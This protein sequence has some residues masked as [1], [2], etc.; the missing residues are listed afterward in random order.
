MAYL[1]NYNSDDQEEDNN[2]K[3]QEA[4]D[5]GSSGPAPIGSGGSQPAPYTQTTALT[6]KK[7][8]DKN[9][10]AQFLGDLTKPYEEDMGNAIQAGNEGLDKFRG[11]IA[12]ESAKKYG[13]NKGE[14]A[15]YEGGDDT[16]A[17]DLRTGLSI[18][19]DPN[20]INFDSHYT[21]GS[22]SYGPQD[23][24]AL[25]TSAGLQAGLKKQLG[26]STAPYSRGMAALDAGIYLPS[27]QIQGQVG[28]LLN[29]YGAGSNTLEQQR[30]ASGDPS[31]A[32]TGDTAPL[33]DNPNSIEGG[34]I[35]EVTGRS[36]DLQDYIKGRNNQI[37]AEAP[38]GDFVSN[39][40]LQD[41]KAK[42][43]PGIQD[44]SLNKLLGGQG[45]NENAA[46]GSFDQ[47]YAD[48]SQYLPQDIYS[49]VRKALQDPNYSSQGEYYVDPT[50]FYSPNV[51]SGSRY[52]NQ[53]QAT[54]ENRINDLLGNGNNASVGSTGQNFDQSGYD[55]ALLQKAMSYVE[56]HK[57]STPIPSDQIPSPQPPS[58]GAPVHGPFGTQG[59]DTI[60]EGAN[61]EGSELVGKDTRK[62]KR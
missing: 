39:Q 1:K 45:I 40:D 57:S 31:L 5:V 42:K 4:P 50:K 21:P 15:G 20:Q 38:T 59:R 17:G 35:S 19:K 60:V 61:G 8:Y 9:Q 44:A 34:A 47:T 46:P 23:Y 52:L 11:D 27:Q 56:N 13:F 41:W 51:Q 2:L 32:K 48:N 10:G 49:Q 53:D 3:G 12:T 30:I 33:S 24:Q 36:R 16:N 7:I 29:D 18:A 62:S 28:Q 14:V 25:G 58:K 54:R 37:D 6:G 26:G 43:A 22:F 55:A